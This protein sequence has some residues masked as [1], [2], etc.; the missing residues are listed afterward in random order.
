MRYI[1]YI[2]WWLYKK[3]EKYSDIERKENA[4]LPPNF[5]GVGYGK[6]RKIIRKKL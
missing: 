5:K 4:I 2:F 6:F 3:T 1:N